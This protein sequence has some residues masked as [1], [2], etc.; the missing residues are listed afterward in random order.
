MRFNIANTKHTD[1]ERVCECGQEFLSVKAEKCY[2]C[3]FAYK[4]ANARKMADISYQKLKTKRIKE[5]QDKKERVQKALQEFAII[6]ERILDE[7]KSKA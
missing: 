5:M 4:M 3:R 6:R 2:D 7:K 1:K